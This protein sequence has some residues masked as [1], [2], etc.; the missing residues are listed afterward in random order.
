MT[1]EAARSETATKRL[2]GEKNAECA[3]LSAVSA[4]LQFEGSTPVRKH[5]LH[6]AVGETVILMTPPFYPY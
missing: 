2:H 3:L 4:S 6:L 1:L 5:R